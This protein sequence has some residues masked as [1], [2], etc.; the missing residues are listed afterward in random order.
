MAKIRILIIQPNHLLR[1]ALA[2]YVQ[3]QEPS[4]NVVASATETG[5][6]LDNLRALQP[7][8]VLVELG[9]PGREGFKEARL[10]R[11]V[12]PEARVLMTGVTGLESDVMACIEAGAAGYL[13]KNASL[14]E[15]RRS[16][17]ATARGETL[18]SPKIAG[19]LFA[20]IREYANERERLRALD[21]VRLTHREREI[22]SCIE[23]GLS[24]KEIAVRL[25]IEVQTV[26][27]HVH[28]ILEKLQLTGRR[29]AAR[30]AIEHGLIAPIG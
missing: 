3:S 9:I 28:N 16:I 5:E 17:E 19:A 25:N 24:N 6:I 2:F 22:I 12:Y 4:L 7:D 13:S 1:D 18:I 14:E 11:R 30:Y 21:L 15:L 23:K 8:V 29:E 20:R 10:V 26:K 27:N